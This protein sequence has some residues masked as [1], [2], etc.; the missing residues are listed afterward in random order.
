MGY[1]VA[2]AAIL[3]KL[4]DGPSSSGIFQGKARNCPKLLT[5]ATCFVDIFCK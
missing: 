2:A 1:T 5:L 3:G 4:G